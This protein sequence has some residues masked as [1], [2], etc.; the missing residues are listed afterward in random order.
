MN[1]DYFKEEGWDAFYSGLSVSDNP[2]TDTDSR[3]QH[4]HTG[5]KNAEFNS[6]LK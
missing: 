3:N 2:Y 5:F 1:R 4:W 6:N